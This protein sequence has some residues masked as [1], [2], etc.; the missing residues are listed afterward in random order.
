[1]PRSVGA[2]LR[3]RRSLRRELDRV[4]LA[5]G[6]WSVV[7]ITLVAL[8]RL[9]RRKTGVVT[10]GVVAAVCIGLGATGALLYHAQHQGRSPTVSPVGA[11]QPVS[12]S[13]E[14]TPDVQRNPAGAQRQPPP[15][16]PAP[17]RPSA[18]RGADSTTQG[19]AGISLPAIVP[20]V[21]L[22]VSPPSLPTTVRV[23][24]LPTVTVPTLPTTVSVPTLPTALGVPALP[25]TVTVPAALVPP[26]TTPAPL[27]VGVPSPPAG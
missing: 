9:V 10:I 13:R 5:G 12:S 17:A 24:S 23:A 4:G 22:P 3:A 18:R 7:A 1:M 8:R 20:A 6:T 15:P 2:V 21:T 27:L 11:R 25:T 16:T 14:V 26:A 19:R